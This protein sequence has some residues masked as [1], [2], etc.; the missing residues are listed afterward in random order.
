MLNIFVGMERAVT[1]FAAGN[2]DATTIAELDSLIAAVV[3]YNEEVQDKDIELDLE[4]L[5][6]LRSNLLAAR[7]PDESV[8]P[9]SNPWPAD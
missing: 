4:L 1:D 5:Q 7:V 3:D 6:M 9:P 2:A 8:P